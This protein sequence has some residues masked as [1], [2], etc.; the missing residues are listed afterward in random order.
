MSAPGRTVISTR[1]SR[2]WRIAFGVLTVIAGVLILVW[3]GAAVLTVAIILG[4]HLIIAG[5]LRAV[6]ALTRDIDS[7]RTRALYLI[8]GLLLV[9]AGT[10][11]LVLPFP[12]AALLVLL[13]GLSWVVNGVIELIH[14]FTGGG[15]WTI[16]SGAVSLAAGI[17]VLAYPAPGILALAWLFGLALIAIGL[18]VTVGAMITGRRAGT[19]AQSQSSFPARDA[20][21]ARHPKDR[22]GGIDAAS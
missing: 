15:G 16:A 10:L 14:G 20:G 22:D 12:A 17:A 4:I 7:G 3:P 13:F 2:G 11:C 19:V 21:A 6:T 9:A 5:V 1:P 18:T 8:L